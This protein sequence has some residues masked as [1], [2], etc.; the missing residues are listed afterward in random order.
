MQINASLGKWT[1]QIYLLYL[2]E[3]YP[4]LSASARYNE[5]DINFLSDSGKTLV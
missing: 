5:L 3:L 4:E 2:N 1:N